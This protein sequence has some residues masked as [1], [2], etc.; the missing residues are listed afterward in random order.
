MGGASH[1][2]QFIYRTDGIQETH[3]VNRKLN[4]ASYFFTS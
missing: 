2:A 4:H 3:F 1:L